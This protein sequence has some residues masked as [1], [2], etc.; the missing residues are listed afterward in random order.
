M[1]KKWIA[2]AIALTVVGLALPVTVAAA[3][4]PPAQAKLNGFE[5]VP[6][7]LTGGQGQFRFKIEGDTIEWELR[8]SSLRGSVQ[9]AHIH[10]AQPDVNG[11]VAVFL[12]TNLGNGPAGT[13]AC[14]APP[15]TISGVA[16][17]GDVVGAA[18][19]QGLAAGEFAR[20][21]VALR[22]GNTYANVHSDLF[23]NGEIRGQIK[24]HPGPH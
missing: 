15:A 10:I 4:G 24:G 11:G 18:S 20:L 19:A 5:E 7:I 14:P 9:Q 1:G 23:P 3:P 2:I 12:C 17:A 6:V 13:Q 16:D 21:L 8:Y 22:S